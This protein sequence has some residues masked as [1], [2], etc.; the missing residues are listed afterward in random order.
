MQGNRR[1]QIITFCRDMIGLCIEVQH[2]SQQQEQKVH[3]SHDHTKGHY[4][5]LGI[6][7]RSHADI[8]L[9]HLLVKPRHSNCDENA[10]DNLLY[11]ISGR[12]HILIENF[13]KAVDI[14]VM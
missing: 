8:L 12:V 13:G 6:F 11:E 5:L 3:D 14:Q 9:H 4:V 2:A 1:K 7:K 10:P